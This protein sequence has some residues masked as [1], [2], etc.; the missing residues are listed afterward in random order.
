MPTIVSIQ[1]LGGGQRRS[2][3]FHPTLKTVSDAQRADELLVESF[4]FGKEGSNP[5]FHP[6]SRDF[7]G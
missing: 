5:W 2:Q 7:S 6:S 1:V 3:K 4:S